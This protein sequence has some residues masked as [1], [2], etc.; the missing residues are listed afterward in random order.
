MR[1]GRERGL[2]PPPQR[3]ELLLEHAPI[4][5]L[6]QAHAPIVGARDHRTDRRV[7]PGETNA[8]RG[9]RLRRPSRPGSPRRLGRRLAEG[10]LERVAESAVRR[11]PRV[12]HRVIDR[13]A[14]ADLLEGAGQPAGAAVGL[15]REAVARREVPAHAV[16]I[17]VHRAEV[18]VGQARVRSRF[19]P[20]EQLPHP[21]GRV[22]TGDRPALEAR[23][24]PG[25]HRL[26]R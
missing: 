5:E 4:R 1:A 25:E 9:G 19:D 24:I 6:Q 11:I 15:E 2:E 20:R 14:V 18:A 3:L 22:V 21:R 23:A 7:D 16:G 8:I 10:L 13:L 12:E 26:F 17:Q